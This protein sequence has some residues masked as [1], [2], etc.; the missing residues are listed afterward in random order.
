[1]KHLLGIVAI[2]SCIILSTFDSFVG[3][4]LVNVAW[5]GVGI[6]VVYMV[7]S[8]MQGKHSDSS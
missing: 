5:W 6:S 8:T 1:M 4:P 3:S 7:L 2:V